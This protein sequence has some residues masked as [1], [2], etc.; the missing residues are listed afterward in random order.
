MVIEIIAM[1][2]SGE[3][4]GSDWKARRQNF[5]GKLNSLYFDQETRV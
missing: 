4:V 3:G 2:V 5:L 1:V